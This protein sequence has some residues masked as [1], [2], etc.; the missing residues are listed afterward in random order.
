M[1]EMVFCRG[2]GKEIHQTAI[3]CPQ[4]GAQQST[5]AGKSKTTATLLA[6]FLGGLGVHRFYLGKWWG[7]FYLLFC[8]TL[9]PGVIATVEAIVFALTD[10]AK[11]DAKYNEGR[12][13]QSG[14]GAVLVLAL[15]VGLFVVISFIGILAAIALPAYQEYSVRAKIAAVAVDGDRIAVAMKDFF[16]SQRKL[17]A[18]TA[19]LGLPATDKYVRAVEIDQKTGVVNME[20]NFAPVQGQ[21][22]M[23]VPSSG[24]QANV[25]WKCGSNDIKQSYLPA[26]CR[27][28]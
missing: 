3:A 2:C 18:D 9:I 7:I 6:L 12:A 13:S 11:W 22:F 19:A 4:C 14:S 5:K 28:N 8:W 25:T 1:S 15:I 23:L 26:K 10:D 21:H 17:P 24:D 16:T 27:Q 20:L